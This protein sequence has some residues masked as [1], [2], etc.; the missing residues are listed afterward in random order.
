MLSLSH[1]HSTTESLMRSLLLFSALSLSLPACAVRAG[2]PKTPA[3]L[4]GQA[5][6][7]R[8][9]RILTEEG[10]RRP[11]MTVGR[12][13]QYGPYKGFFDV[14]P[15]TLK[16]TFYYWYGATKA[17][18]SATVNAWNQRT[19]RTGTAVAQ[20]GTVFVTLDVPLPS[21]APDAVLRTRIRGLR[22]TLDAFSRTL[23]ASGEVIPTP[24]TVSTFK[25]LLGMTAGAAIAS[26][27][28]ADATGMLEAISNGADLLT[29]PTSS[30][31]QALKAQYVASVTRSPSMTSPEVAAAV[32]R[33]ATRAAVA[34]SS[35]KRGT[36]PPTEA[37]PSAPVAPV[38]RTVNGVVS[39]QARVGQKP[40]QADTGYSGW[41]F[42]QGDKPI[43]YRVA[44]VA[45]LG[46]FATFQVQLR[47]NRTDPIFCTDPDCAGYELTLMYAD[48]KGEH[49]Y[50]HYFLFENT[51]AEIYT[52]PALVKVR[53]RFSDGSVRKFSNA[54]LFT[55]I[56]PRDG[57]EYPSVAIRGCVNQLL[58]SMVS[59]RCV[60]DDAFVAANA[61]TLRD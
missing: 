17:V 10:F 60:F 25:T 57:N 48:E 58:H 40:V 41:F 27:N 47:L 16:V 11:A 3:T 54:K 30:G 50:H 23:T 39:P 52:L 20:R 7:A 59:R 29:D 34:S 35:V 42:I 33:A 24:D 51:Y 18:Q 32:Q 31:A 12:I 36:T 15:D 49:D 6:S 61:V 38:R 45:S 13:R 53:M 5:E 56:E 26:A 8:V 9:K 46:D 43:Q 19:P 14:A 44:Q 4:A 22:Q 55:Y 28:G 2:L 1:R 21:S 37:P